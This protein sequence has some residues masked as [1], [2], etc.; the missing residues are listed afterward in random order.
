LLAAPHHPFTT[1]RPPWMAAR[2]R[3]HLDGRRSAFRPSHRDREGLRTDRYSA[4]RSVAVT[5]SRSDRLADVVVILAYAPILMVL[6]VLL[7]VGLV[8]V[9]VPGGFIIVLG[10]LYY[11][12]LGFTGLLALAARGRWRAGASR[13]RANTSRDEAPRSGR[14]SFGPRPAA[15]PRPVA[16]GFT[17]DRAVGSAPKLAQSRRASGDINLVAPLERGRVPGRQDDARAA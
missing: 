3:P 14:S 11:A 10:G 8:F 5:H 7:V 15:A 17:S 9:V 6:P 1:I 13:R 4:R 16:V 2:R 12:V